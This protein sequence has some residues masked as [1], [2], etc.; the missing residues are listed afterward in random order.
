M[1]DLKAINTINDRPCYDWES[2]VREQIREWNLSGFWDKNSMMYKNR[3][4]SQKWKEYH[5]EWS[6]K[7]S[8]YLKFDINN[9]FQILPS[10]QNETFGTAST[11]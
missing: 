2:E 10:I 6:R 5:S 4:L 3:K 7:I 9:F 11:I 1:V 8:I